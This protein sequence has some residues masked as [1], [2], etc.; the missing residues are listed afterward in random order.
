MFKDC[1]KY[2]NLLVCQYDYYSFFITVSLIT[3]DYF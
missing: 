2:A 1:N 3:P